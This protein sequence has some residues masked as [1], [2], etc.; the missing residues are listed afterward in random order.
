MLYNDDCM[1]VLPE[2]DDNSVDMVLV[3]LPYGTTHNSWDSVI[4]LDKLWEQYNRVVKINGAMVFTAQSPFNIVLANSNLENYRYEWIWHKNK[5]TGHLNAKRMPMKSHENVLVFYR[6]LPTY[7]PQ[8]TSGHTKRNSSVTKN[9][10]V[11]RY[12]DRNYQASDVVMNE[13]GQ[14]DR[15]PR[16][17]L[18]IPVHNNDTKDKF[19]PTQKPINLM[20]YFIQTYT[21]EGDVVLDNAMGAGTTCIACVKENRKYI[22]I[23]KDEFYFNK[24]KERIANINKNSLFMSK[25]KY[26]PQTDYGYLSK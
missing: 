12:K 14:T 22:G 8:K 21:N 18:E 17:V 2:L 24:A 7:N 6:K 19:H 26:H 3:D 1:N 11:G 5:S 4:P 23:E 15:Y 10:Y 13:G 25:Y 16:S 20:R 9:D